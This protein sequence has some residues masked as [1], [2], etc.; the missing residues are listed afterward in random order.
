MKAVV[1][2]SD[3]LNG[4][5]QVAS[6]LPQRPTSLQSLQNILV[7]FGAASDALRV[8][9]TDLEIAMI[10]D[11][12]ARTGEKGQLSLP[13]KKLIESIRDLP[14]DEVTLVSTEK[15]AL[16]IKSG[17][18]RTILR[19]AAREE[20]PNLPLTIAADGSISFQISGGVGFK[21][22][23]AVFKEAIR[24]TLV[25]ASRDE[26]R[27]FL[28]GANLVID[29][30]KSRLV[31]TDG[32]RL[33]VCDFPVAVPPEGSVEAI[34]P[35]RILEAVRA[36]LPAAG[37]VEVE[38]G[39][40]QVVFKSDAGIFYSRL[41]SEKFPDYEKII[42]KPSGNKV[43]INREALIDALRCVSHFANA[44]TSAVLFAFKDDRVIVSAETPEFGES[45]SEVDAKLTGT[46]AEISFNA[47][48]LLDGLK[49]LSGEELVFELG[50]KIAPAV[51]TTKEDDP[52]KYILM[53]L[54][55]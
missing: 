32:H 48:Y 5:G 55:Q 52:Y 26:S 44:R 12:P 46:A 6:A 27:T 25:A 38:V 16:T 9:A 15:Q 31:S 14:D 36:G 28:T 41:I 2:K 39:E 20:Y 51:M 30:K 50:A 23:T 10:V 7:D 34:I 18:S 53:P 43:L 35:L 29:E 4:L 1:S 42:P 19:G 13:G 49:A 11:I 37:Q 22:D 17:K 21:V 45:Q 47:H 3:L 8:T 33:A 24:K 54:R 40:T